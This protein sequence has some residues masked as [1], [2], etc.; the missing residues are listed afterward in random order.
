MS[1]PKAIVFFS[2]GLGDAILLIPLVKVLK[3]NGYF[4]TGIFNSAMPCQ[5]MMAQTGLL[6]ELIDAS[7]P[8]KQAWITIARRGKYQFAVINY[9]ATRRTNFMMAAALAKKIVSNRLPAHTLPEK[10]KAKLEL[11]QPEKGIHD[12]LQNLLLIGKKT[13]SLSDL[14]IPKLAPHPA[15][16]GAYIALQVTSGNSAVAYKNWPLQ[17]WKEFFTMLKPPNTKYKFVLLGNSSDIIAAKEL[18]KIYPDIVSLAGQTTITEAMQVLSHCSMFLGLDSGLMHLATA[19]GKPT[20]TLWGPSS[21]ILY[22]YEQFDS[23]H[24]RCIRAK[25]TCHPCNAWIGT[26]L[27]KTSAPENCPDNACM[28]ELSAM[29]VYT[30]FTN[31]VN[32]LPKHVS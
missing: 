23:A 2:A 16:E 24:H 31:F 18:Q 20:F 11:G 14:S 21:E 15:L 4:V 19:F 22:G 32:S 17:R 7:S 29:E 13:F 5:E 10:V 25:G 6:D 9:F 3:A 1:K 26:N 8:L 28:M 30:Q 12:A 27:S